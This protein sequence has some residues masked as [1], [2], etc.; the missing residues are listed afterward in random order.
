MEY[1]TT[2]CPTGRRQLP[3]RH[4]GRLR[5]RGQEEAAHEGRIINDSNLSRIHREDQ[6]DTEAAVAAA[7]AREISN[8]GRRRQPLLYDSF[9]VVTPSDSKDQ[10][11]WG[12]RYTHYTDYLPCVFVYVFDDDEE[13]HSRTATRRGRERERVIQFTLVLHVPQFTSN[14]G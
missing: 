4:S 13:H 1:A 9:L 14:H 7:H 3:P 2:E 11:L 8:K 5:R 6:N 10:S 12:P